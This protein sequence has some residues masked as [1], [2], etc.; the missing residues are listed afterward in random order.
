M[1]NKK[2]FYFDPEASGPAIFLGP[3]EAALMEIAWSKNEITVKL[4]LVFLG[5]KTPR[6]YTTV[7]TVLGNLTTKSLLSRRRSGRSFVYQPVVSREAFLRAK[8]NIVQSCLKRN[9]VDT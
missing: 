5:N 6:A 1:A 2:S 9:F 8:A 4:A 7:M 3:T